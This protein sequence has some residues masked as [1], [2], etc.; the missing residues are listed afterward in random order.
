ML[1]GSCVLGVFW[2]FWFHSFLTVYSG[3]LFLP[4][5]VLRDYMFLEI[6]PFHTG[7]PVCGHIVVHSNFLQYLVFCDIS[8][9]FS[10]FISHF[11]YLDPLSFFWW[12]LLKICPSCFSF[13][14]TSSWFRWLF[15]LFFSLYVIDF[16]SDLD[17]FPLSTFS[18]VC[19]LLFS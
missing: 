5:S 17:Y 18:R 9:Y 7:W 4:V 3:F 19:L 6:Y 8:C 1:A 16:H 15:V 12:V 11:V 13:Q 10:S 2:L 14:R